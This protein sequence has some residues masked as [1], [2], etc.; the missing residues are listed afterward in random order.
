MLG[1]SSLVLLGRKGG[2]KFYYTWEGF[3]VL[4]KV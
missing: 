2:R 4:H 1:R 3:G